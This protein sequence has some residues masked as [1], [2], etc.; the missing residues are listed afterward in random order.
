M[1]IKDQLASFQKL[2]INGEIS[3]HVGIYN[4]ITPTEEYGTL[5]SGGEYRQIH[6]ESQAE[7]DLRRRRSTPGRRGETRRREM[8]EHTERP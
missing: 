7:V 1:N 2:G 8:E 5:S 3:S 4:F 6:G